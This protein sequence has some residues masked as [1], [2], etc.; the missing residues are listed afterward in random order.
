MASIIAKKFAHSRSGI[1]SDKLQGCGITGIGGNHNGVIHGAMILKGFNNFSH[2]R[3]PLT[4]S[5]VDTDDIFTLLIDDGI[6]G[7]CRFA[8]L[9]IANDQLALSATDGNHGIDGLQPGCKRF[10]YRLAGHYTGGFPFDQRKGIRLN[11]TPAIQ[12]LTQGINHATDHGLT[13]RYRGN[14]IRSLYQ[15]TF[16]DYRIFA[17]KYDTNVV[18]LQ[19]EHHSDDFM[20]EFYQ[21][22]GHYFFQA[23]DA[24]NPIPNHQNGSYLVSV[25]F[26]LISFESLFQNC[27]DFIR[28]H[29]ILHSLF[30]LIVITEQSGAHVI[31]SVDCEYYY[32]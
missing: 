2:R 10:F 8:G 18:F 23:M 28:S 19:I 22:P 17:E 29:R 11:L 31:Y 21:L 7:Q 30:L 6:Q 27:R 1:G 4:N 32:Q 20:G 12:W 13:G 25:R 5:Y 24:G 26:F 15:I 16:F 14:S 9:A 3:C